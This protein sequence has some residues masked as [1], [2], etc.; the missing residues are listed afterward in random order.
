VAA[1]W[2]EPDAGV[3][4]IRGDPAHHVHS[5]LMAWLAL[6]RACRIAE[7]HP[8]EPAQRARW[9]REREAIAADVFERGFDPVRNTF[10]RAYGRD[11]L[12]AALLVLPLLG[13]EPPDSPWVRGTV[14]AVRQELGAG[15]P[16]LYRYRPGD[17]GIAG[18]EGA[19]L[20]CSF[21]MVQALAATGDVDDAIEQMAQLVDLGGPLGLFAEE[22]DP[23]TGALLGNHP[24][25]FTH[26]TLVQAALAIQ[27]ATGRGAGPAPTRMPRGRPS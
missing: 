5:K 20:P 1:C 8:A 26:A 17:D 23:A 12:D 16:L 18:G 6:D 19:F 14:A 9:Q 2:R 25:A 11:D 10:V 27:D 24:Q 4:E 15:G 7:T 22:A 21:W 13:I 3:W